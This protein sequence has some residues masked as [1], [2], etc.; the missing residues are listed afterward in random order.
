M[1]S[2]LADPTEIH[3]AVLQGDGI[4]HE[5]ALV[6][7]LAKRADAAAARGE[8]ASATGLLDLTMSEPSWQT[9]N[10]KAWIHATT[11]DEEYYRPLQAIELARRGCE[12]CNYSKPAIVDTLGVAYAATGDFVKAI[13]LC[14]QAMTLASGRELEL[15]AANLRLFEAGKTVREVQ[16]VVLE[17]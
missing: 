14:Q 11:W 13:E 8:V 16:P 5:K 7:L 2:L 12:M 4:T 10:S 9:L 15:I 1:L 6:M 17:Q 3:L